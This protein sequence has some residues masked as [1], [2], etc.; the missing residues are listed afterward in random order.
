MTMLYH[1]TLTTGH[2][3]SSPRAEVSDAVVAR[4]RPLVRA[5]G[6]I[7]IGLG[8]YQVLCTAENGAAVY[9]LSHPEYGPCLTC[10]LCW[11]V[12]RSADVWQSV[13]RLH[14]GITESLLQAGVT[15]PDALMAMPEQPAKLPWLAVVL[16]GSAYQAPGLM[17]WAGDWERCMAWAILTEEGMA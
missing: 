3:R 9:T 13:T 14:M 12:E 7:D 4:V 1:L 15:L 10:G 11:R 8:L 17:D 5:Q 6:K 16:M 2:M